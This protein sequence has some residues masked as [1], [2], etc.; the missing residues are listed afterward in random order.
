MV[1]PGGRQPVGTVDHVT[2]VGPLRPA[3][4]PL[5]VDPGYR[6]P[7]SVQW[8]TSDEQRL[9][10]F[11][12]PPWIDPWYARSTAHAHRIVPPDPAGGQRR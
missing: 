9:A 7:Y 6:S 8:R 3:L 11:D 2:T 1:L 4:R 5:D 12:R 10:G